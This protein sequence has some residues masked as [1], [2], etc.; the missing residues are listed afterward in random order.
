MTTFV[1]TCYVTSPQYF[2]SRRHVPRGARIRITT[3]SNE[4]LEAL[5]NDSVHVTPMIKSE[6]DK[7]Q[8]LVQRESM[9]QA[10]AYKVLLDD[11]ND[12]LTSLYNVLNIITPTDDTRTIAC[13]FAHGKPSEADRELISVAAFHG[14][15]QPTTLF[16][17]DRDMIELTQQMIRYNMV[18]WTDFRCYWDRA[19]QEQVIYG[20]RNR[21]T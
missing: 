20:D 5:L 11:H 6:L 12:L 2:G 17:R 1:D 3:K 7:Y 21:F 18:P 8:E 19:W 4:H 14:L 10:N 9:R 15:E 16:T 13:Q